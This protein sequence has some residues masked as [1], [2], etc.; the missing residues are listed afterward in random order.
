M[1]LLQGDGPPVVFV[2]GNGSTH[3]TWAGTIRHLT[4]R[5]AC[6]S[7][8]LPGHGGPTLPPGELDLRFFVEDLERVR[9]RHGLERAC[10]VGHSLGAFIVAAYALAHPAR[11]SG[12]CLLAAPAG[13]SEAEEAAGRQLV[14]A[15]RS[16]GVALT[17]GKLVGFWYTDDFVRRF[18]E[19]LEERLRQ[20]A[21]LDEDV[22]IRAYDLY[23]RTE[24]APWLPQIR[25]PVLVLT[26]E[27]ARGA[28]AAVARRTADA[29]PDAKLVVLTGLRNGILTEVPDIV[30]DEIATF[31]AHVRAGPERA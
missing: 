31:V 2:H 27:H 18:P 12:L 13:R 16:D 29:L 17:M 30:A 20:V 3:E 24:I 10:L 7:Y 21:G 15:L 28:S 22:F 6:L 19:A 23:T 11:V 9:A 1:E 26:G 5:F 8:D 4:D 14:A 25:V